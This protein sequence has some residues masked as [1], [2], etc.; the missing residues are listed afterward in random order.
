MRDVHRSVWV[1]CALRGAPAV[2]VHIFVVL[3]YII[4]CSCLCSNVTVVVP[5]T[6]ARN[7]WHWVRVSTTW[8]LPCQLVDKLNVGGLAHTCLTYW[9]QH[10]SDATQ[11]QHPTMCRSTLHSMQHNK[12]RVRPLSGAL[13]CAAC[14]LSAKS[15]T[16]RRSDRT[17]A[18]KSEKG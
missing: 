5:G 8:V 17:A 9:S 4:W 16:L 18:N 15:H 14:C 13:A 6:F 10:Y 11:R 7:Q 3:H 1:V 2:G 12:H